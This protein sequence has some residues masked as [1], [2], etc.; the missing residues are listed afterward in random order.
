MPA[1]TGSERP[2][3]E[4][5][6]RASRFGVR[7]DSSSVLPPGSFGMPPRPSMTNRT[8]LEGV[9]RTSSETRLDGTGLGD[10]TIDERIDEPH[11]RQAEERAGQGAQQGRAVAQPQRGGAA[12]D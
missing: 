7:A 9:S 2:Q 5:A 8:I 11:A 4:L 6:A 1:P 10:K 3:S 12:V